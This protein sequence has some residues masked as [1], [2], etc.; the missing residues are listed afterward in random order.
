M[1]RKLGK[2][3]LTAVIIVLALLIRFLPQELPLLDKYGDEYFNSAIVKAVT[4]YAAAR[5]INAIVSVAKETEVEV[6]FSFLF[7]GSSTIHVGQF[8]DPVDDAVERLSTVLTTSIASLG[9]MKIS[10][11]ILQF[12]TP[13]LISYMLLLLIPGIWWLRFRKFSRFLMNLMVLLLALRLA[14]PVSGIVNN[15]I[16]ADVFEPQI[17]ESLEIL[18]LVGDDE[19]LSADEDKGFIDNLKDKAD[20]LKEG[21]KRLW[22]NKGEIVN[23]LVGLLLLY[24]SMVVVQVILIPLIVIWVLIKLV[25]TLFEKRLSIEDV[26]EALGRERQK[27][28]SDVK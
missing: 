24:I 13:K 1:M 19:E 14:L 8:L 5:I 20:A 22:Q 2:K 15:T 25:N 16:Y 28:G 3:K 4:T 26:M 17:Q 12:Y 23:A 21:A 6:G 11:E 10:K 18:S 9:L 27:E 7:S